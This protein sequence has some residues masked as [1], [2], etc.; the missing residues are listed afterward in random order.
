MLVGW[1]ARATGRPVRWTET[2]SESMVAL[3]PGRAMVLDFELGASREG[4]IE[5]LKLDILADAGAYPGLGAFLPNLTALMSSGVY[6]IPKIEANIRAVVDQHHADRPG[7]RRGPTRGHP[8]A[9][10]RDGPARGRAVARS[11][12]DQAAQLH[13][14]RRLPVHDRLWRALRHRRLRRGPGAG[15][16]ERRLR[17]SAPR[18]G[19]PAPER[20]GHPARDRPQRVRRGDQRHLRAGVRRGRDHPSRRGDRPHRLAVA[21]PGPRDD[22]RADRGR[23]ARPADREGHA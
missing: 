12:R 3:Q 17:R 13:P 2:R 6:R 23:T 5:G 18:A 7:A 19:R 10:A 9:R 21:G 8:D 14:Q 20:L 11:R 1:L 16:R 15:A 4:V 22:L